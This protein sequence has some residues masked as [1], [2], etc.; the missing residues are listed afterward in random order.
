MPY[1]PSARKRPLRCAG[2]NAGDI[3]E[4]PRCSRRFRVGASV[5]RTTGEF[6][7]DDLLEETLGLAAQL[8]GDWCIVLA[9]DGLA[10]I[11]AAARR[12]L[13]AETTRLWRTG[14]WIFGVRGTGA[15]RLVRELSHAANRAALRRRDARL[16]FVFR[17]A[18]LASQVP[19]GGGAPVIE[20]REVSGLVGVLAAP[21]FALRR[22]KAQSRA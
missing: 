16:A 12:S 15:A 5:E 7:H 19:R 17:D 14:Q 13:G 18:S 11:E 10:E 20:Q 9:G 2:C 4:E 8:A 6:D 21:G 22:P 3:Q 1:A